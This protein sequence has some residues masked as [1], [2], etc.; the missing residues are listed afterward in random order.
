MSD[1]LAV[2]GGKP[3]RENP[4]PYGKQ[5]I[6]QDDIDSVIEVLKSD[7]LTTGPKVGEFEK[8]FAEYVGVKHA[9]A[10]SNGTAALHAAAFAAGIGD[11][12]EVVTTPMTFA[13]S[14]NCILYMGGKPVFADVLPNTYNIDPDD[15]KKKITQ[16]TKAIIPVDF[17]GQ[18]VLMDEILEIAEEHGLLVIEDAAHSLGAEYKGKKI[19]SIAH[20]S[21]FSFHPVKHITTGEGGMIT[22]NDDKL[23][24]RLSIFRT[25][26]ITRDM[27]SLKE[28]HGGWYYEQQELGFNYRIT[29]M[30]CA[31]GLSQLKKVEGFI[32]RRIKIAQFYDEHFLKMD[33]IAVQTQADGTRSSWHIYLIRLN[34][35]KLRAGRKEIFD[36]LK[37]ENI[38]VNV[39][40]IPVY[41]HPY[42][43]NLGYKKGLC[44]IA[45][46]LYEDFITLPLYPSMTDND[47]KD[48]VNAVQK[49]I[50][51]YRI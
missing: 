42:Y 11:G 39:H 50:S 18:P 16:K 3:V 33:E 36:A 23:Y 49:V 17:T 51:Y 19:G 10:V 32:K 22:T 30:Q 8:E 46:D 35:S 31:L 15:I 41:L 6:E 43:K 24:K 9:V 5:T 26:G 1:K 38:G 40:Y 4:L 20:M 25:H 37:A 29:D 47:V 7:Y 27:N 48:V 14:A 45:E 13:A 28:N 2:F 12:D 34:S 44:P 21:T